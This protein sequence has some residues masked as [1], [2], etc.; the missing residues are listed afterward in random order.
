MKLHHFFIW[1]V[2]FLL[3]ANTI[4]FGETIIPVPDPPS[5]SAR[6]YVLED[7]KTGQIIAES[8]A[9]QRVAP[10]SIT[11][12]MTAYIVFSEL[13]R[14]NLHLEDQVLIS[15]HAW[16]TGGSRTFIEV[17]TQIPVEILI[18]GMVIQSGNDASVALAEH[19][20]GTE[21]VFAAIMNQQA[22]KLGMT[23]SHFMN[24]TGLPSDNHYAT[25]RDIS[26]LARAIIQDF[27]EYYGWFSQESFTYN[28]IA[29]YN[30]DTLLKR[31]PSVDGLK[32]GYTK[33]AGYCL[34][35]SAKREDMRL[36]SVI[37]RSKSPQSRA[38]E[39]LALLNYG[40]RFYET[41]N[42]YS[43]LEPITN[44]SV[45]R[46]AEKEISLGVAHDLAVVLPRGQWKKLSSAIQVTNP[47][48]APIKKGEELGAIT[49]KFKGD[50]ILEKPLIALTAIPEGN[51]WQKMSDWVSSL[52]SKETP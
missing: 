10:A 15:E 46:G 11:K 28:G 6:S 21:E 33:A 41:N 22:Q 24:S 47:I 2:F 38:N 36:I 45:R 29:Q 27:P 20:A 3:F 19:I 50:P 5:I 7:F 34:V 32:T 23:G 52:F 18:K 48:I 8:Q 30:R 14:G 39:A 51:R 25:A 12:L 16:R 40:F 17:N 26:T 4:A 35:S 44:T 1:H 13:K 49:V 9:D 37:M 43:A 42:I 31:D